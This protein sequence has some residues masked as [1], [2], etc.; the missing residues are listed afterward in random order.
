MGGIGGA[1]DCE[2]SFTPESGEGVRSLVWLIGAYWRCRVGH[3]KFPDSGAW[4]IKKCVESNTSVLF[5]YIF[6]DR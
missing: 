1:D 6:L 2:N 4:G 5:S 3:S